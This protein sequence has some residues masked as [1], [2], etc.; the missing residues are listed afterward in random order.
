MTWT[1][2]LELHQAEELL[3]VGVPEIRKGEEG[4][5]AGDI[6][7]LVSDILP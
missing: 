5:V 4:F 6:V 7:K 2:G 3:D 1:W